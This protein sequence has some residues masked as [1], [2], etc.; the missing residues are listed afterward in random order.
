[1]D[2]FCL[3]D[4]ACI[5][6]ECA[7]RSQPGDPCD[8][9]DDTDC[10][11]AV[12]CGVD[13]TCGGQAADC[14]PNN[15]SLCD[16]DRP[17]LCVQ[18]TCEPPVSEGSMCFENSDCDTGLTCV[19]TC[20]PLVGVGGACNDPNDC[21]PNVECVPGPNGE[22]CG[23]NS[24]SCSLNDH[25]V[26]TC[27]NLVCQNKSTVECDTH[28]FPDSADC[29]PPLVCSDVGQCLLQ[30]GSLCLDNDD[31]INVCLINHCG[32]QSNHGGFCDETDD[33][34]N[35]YECSSNV[36]LSPIGQGCN[37]N[38]DCIDTC[39]DQVCAIHNGSG[40]LC[41]DGEDCI[42]PFDCGQ[43]ICG[44]VGADCSEN[45][46]DLCEAS[47]CIANECAEPAL[48]AQICE[49]DSDCLHLNCGPNDVCGSLG[50][51]CVTDDECIPTIVC[52]DFIC[53]DL[54]EIGELCDVGEADC[55]PGISCGDDGVCGGDNAG[56][57]YC[58]YDPYAWILSI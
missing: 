16:V 54:A 56:K 30:D 44:G 3:N 32:A 13:S 29:L 39:I 58:Y 48:P 45:N 19:G 50:A 22:T 37:E 12:A 28:P 7:N 18:N 38:S 1:M 51:S 43:G 20:V 14:T 4:M 25:C 49:D 35:P 36:C 41:D 55:V 24:A 8:F 5:N 10:F 40:E 31:C 9:G 11:G 17:L 57:Y 52:I 15:S 33:C 6:N 2:A 21:V 53:S 26:N 23:G 27:I 46:D 34:Q 47:V 42:L